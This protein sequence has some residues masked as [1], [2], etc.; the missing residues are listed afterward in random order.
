VMVPFRLGFNTDAQ[1][2]VADGVRRHTHI[3]A[4]THM[5]THARLSG[6]SVT[7]ASAG[8]CLRGMYRRVFHRRPRRQLS[9]GV[10][11]QNWSGHH[12]LTQTYTFLCSACL[13]CA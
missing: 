4:R 6:L 11:R 7:L 1:G 12:I 2:A 8:V 13:A 5:H 9:N 3:H 10:L